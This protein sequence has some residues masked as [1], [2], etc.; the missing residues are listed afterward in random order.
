MFN[1][2]NFTINLVNNSTCPRKTNL[3]FNLEKTIDITISA[4]TKPKHNEYIY[5]DSLTKAIVIDGLTAL[6]IM[7]I[8]SLTITPIPISVIVISVA[9]SV[10]TATISYAIREN[11]REAGHEYQGGLLGGFI[12]YAGRDTIAASF[13]N[14]N[15]VIDKVIGNGIIGAGNNLAYEMLNNA[16]ATNST[17]IAA[18]ITIETIDST[19]N[20]S[21]IKQENIC[22]GIALG[23]LGG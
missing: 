22:E 9:S 2:N 8:I 13:Y 6:E 10:C 15:D 14:K 5:T 20:Y 23:F 12:K 1:P 3:Y 17:A 16:N 19:A 4:L 18:I 7:V 11:E 21:F